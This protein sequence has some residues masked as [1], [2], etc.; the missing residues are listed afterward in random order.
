MV[1]A[2]K[3]YDCFVVLR[4]INRNDHLI[5]GAGAYRTR[6]IGG[7]AAGSHRCG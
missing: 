2:T 3:I 6:D 5:P 1:R 7:E 4:Y